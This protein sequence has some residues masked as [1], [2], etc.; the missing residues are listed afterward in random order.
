MRVN[1]VNAHSTTSCTL[2]FGLR[3]GYPIKHKRLQ[4]IYNLLKGSDVVVYQSVR[5]LGLEPRLNT[6]YDRDAYS[7]NEGMVIDKVLHFYPVFFAKTTT[8]TKQFA[9]KSE[10]GVLVCQNGGRMSNPHY[11]FNYDYEKRESIEWV[12]PI[13]TYKIGRAHV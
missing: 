3:H 8:T 9:I 13:T 1:P 4:D 2:A 12:T 7:S 5:A 11:R 6:Y 10:G